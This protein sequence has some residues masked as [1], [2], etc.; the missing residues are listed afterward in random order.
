MVDYEVMTAG[1]LAKYLQLDEQTI[2]RKAQKGQIPALRIGKTL[3]FKKDVIDSWIRLES[4]QWGSKE[5]E[6]L[7]TWGKNFAKA[8]GI[9]E[10]SL[11]RSIDKRRRS[12]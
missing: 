4:L 6:E 12:R 2:Y 3:R 7:R 11:Q 9:N 8:T 5:R 1:Q 10:K